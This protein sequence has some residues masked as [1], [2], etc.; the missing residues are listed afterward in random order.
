ME[1]LVSS[2]KFNPFKN[3][4]YDVFLN[5]NKNITLPKCFKSKKKCRCFLK[6]EKEV[7]FSFDFPMSFIQIYKRHIAK[8]IL[9]TEKHNNLK[10]LKLKKSSNLANKK[11]VSNSM[12]AHKETLDVFLKFIFNVEKTTTKRYQKYKNY[13]NERNIV[14]EKYLNSIKNEDLE[15]V[16]PLVVLNLSLYNHYHTLKL[17]ECFV[18]KLK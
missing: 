14:C 3:N 6:K 1:F 11:L 17:F 7:Q 15:N 10:I 2:K 4:F 18:N 12:L 13:I 5:Y 9:E 8:Y 16:T